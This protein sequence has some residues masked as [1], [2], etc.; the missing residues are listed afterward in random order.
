MQCSSLASLLDHIISKAEQFGT[1]Y[2]AE[3][4]GGFGIDGNLKFCRLHNRS[5]FRMR[6]AGLI[7]KAL[8]IA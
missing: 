8:W 3:R 1:D 6:P 4:L 7:R 5:P 2:N